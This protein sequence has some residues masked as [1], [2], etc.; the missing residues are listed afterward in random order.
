MP[1]HP[2][3]LALPWRRVLGALLGLTALMA[4]VTVLL[5]LLLSTRGDSERSTATSATPTTSSVTPSSSST[6]PAPSPRTTPVV[7]RGSG[8]LAPVEVT[9]ADTDREGREVR[10]SVE[11]EEGIGVD[12]AAFGRQ[13]RTILLDRRG[14]ESE[15]SVH[16]VRVPAARVRAGAPVDVRVILASP[17]TTD[18][19]CLPLDT[20]G[21][22]SCGREGR[23]VINSRRWLQGAPSYAGRLEGYRQYVINHE[24]G[25]LLGH[26]HEGCHEK[27]GPAPVMLQQ[28]IGLL[29]CT[30]WSWPVGDGTNQR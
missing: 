1:R 27:G 21:K 11:V 16:F 5:T 23:A 30:A 20:E 28:T 3:P 4:L 15:D 18:S 26:P 8:R 22:Y 25:H 10:W 17:K 14:W 24:V 6:A 2:Q 29:G 7:T 13:V 19:L 9:G 12:E